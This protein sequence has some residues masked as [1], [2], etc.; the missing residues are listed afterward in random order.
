MRLWSELVQ[1]LQ[2]EVDLRF[3]QIR[4]NAY[5][6]PLQSFVHQKF[7]HTCCSVLYLNHE[8]SGFSKM[9]YDP[10]YSLVLP[11]EWTQHRIEL[12]WSI[13]ELYCNGIC[14]LQNP[15]WLY[16]NT[17]SK[18]A[19][20]KLLWWAN[21]PLGQLLCL[22]ISVDHSL[23]NFIISIKTADIWVELLLDYPIVWALSDPTGFG[24]L[25]GLENVSL[26]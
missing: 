12:W 15:V 6:T 24:W 23:S 3:K 26:G 19:A 11:Y 14:W 7:S 5:K 25:M 8:T 18:L 21:G 1:I 22:K 17:K 20:G 4:M 16:T 9:Q 2:V 13:L 10:A